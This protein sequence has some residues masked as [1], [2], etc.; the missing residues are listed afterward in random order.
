MMTLTKDKGALVKKDLLH[1]RFSSTGTR[2]VNTPPNIQAQGLHL[3]G[4]MPLPTAAM[5]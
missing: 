1:V 4:E 5:G 2:N 3:P